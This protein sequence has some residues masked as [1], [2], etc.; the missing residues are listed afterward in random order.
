MDD[1]DDDNLVDLLLILWDQ[2]TPDGMKIVPIDHPHRN[3]A[4][5]RAATVIEMQI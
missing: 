2:V 5:F 4:N 1:V 3:V